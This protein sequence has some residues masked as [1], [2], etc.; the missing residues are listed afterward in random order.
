MRGKKGR[1]ERKV[2]AREWGSVS[3]FF[4]EGEHWFHVVVQ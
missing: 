1:E 2:G 4:V 3:T